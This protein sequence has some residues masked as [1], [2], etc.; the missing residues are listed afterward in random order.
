[1]T[2][3]SGAT[4][5][6]AR[7]P[8]RTQA[9]RS[10]ATRAKLLRATLECLAERGYAR[11]STTEV[12]QRA[13]VSRGAQLHHFPT[14]AELVAAA[15]AY[16]LERRVEE[17]TATVGAIAPGPER[18]EAVIDLLWGIFQSPAAQAWH[19]LVVAARTDD[20]LRPHVAAIAERLDA[21][22]RTAWAELF[23]AGLHGLDPA[24]NATV[25]AFLF[26]VLNGLSTHC[27]SGASNADRDAEQVLGL[28]KALG[29]YF[30]VVNPL[31]V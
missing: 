20:E 13:G 29:A 8:R 19:E 12:C 5:A 30:D 24:I 16:V 10:E 28:V 9:E 25:P 26:A 2:D 27:M 6:R 14:K 7:P 11:T 3:A 18:V 1:M 22:V 15:A 17:V 31:E 4:T 21:E 23:P